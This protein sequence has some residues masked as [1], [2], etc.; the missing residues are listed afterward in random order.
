MRSGI[1]GLTNVNGQ[2]TGN[3]T[4]R[5]GDSA[6]AQGLINPVFNASTDADKVN[7]SLTV[8]TGI[9]AQFGQNASKAVGDYGSSKLKEAQSLRDQAAKLQASGN[10]QDQAQAQSLLTQAGSIEAAW[11][12]GGTA[13]V[14]A[15]AIVGGLTGGNLSG[16]LGAGVSAASMPVIGQ[17]IDESTLPKE[18]KGVIGGIAAA[19]I[20]AAASGGSVVSHHTHLFPLLDHSSCTV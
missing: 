16:A 14:A 7:K 1:S 17:A 10:E 12:E 15:H 3:S 5:T 11:K 8:Q 2:S 19:A 20:G 13:R 9:T 6:Q 18:L 4:A